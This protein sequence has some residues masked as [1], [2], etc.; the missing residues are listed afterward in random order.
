[1]KLALFDTHNGMIALLDPVISRPSW[2]AVVFQ[3]DG[4]G[5]AMKGLFED[6][7]RRGRNL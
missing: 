5:E 2:T 4:M 6:H 7:W 3:H 1:M